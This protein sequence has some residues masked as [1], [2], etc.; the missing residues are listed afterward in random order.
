[1]LETITANVV[2]A[3]VKQKTG[4]TFKRPDDNTYEMKPIVWYF[5]PP[6]WRGFKHLPYYPEWFDC[7]DRCDWVK[8]EWKRNHMKH[9]RRDKAALPV[10]RVDVEVESGK[11]A[12]H[13]V[14]ATEGIFFLER[15][16]DSVEF[17]RDISKFYEVEG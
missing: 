9:P 15:T 12:C 1:M 13:L 14:I 4:L 2:R 17:V 11:H 5:K 7:D 6:S 3:I 16:S 8:V 10:F